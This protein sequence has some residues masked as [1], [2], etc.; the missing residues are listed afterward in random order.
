M[1]YVSRRVIVTGLTK[2]QNPHGDNE[3]RPSDEGGVLAS[4]TADHQHHPLFG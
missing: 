3:F 1:C 2:K 4:G